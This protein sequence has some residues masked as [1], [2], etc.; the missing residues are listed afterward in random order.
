MAWTYSGDPSTSA[1]DMVRFLIADTDN[2][3]P[4]MTDAELDTLLTL[5]G[6]AEDTAYVCVKYLM[7][8][9][10]RECDYTIG[11]ESVKASQRYK[12]YK[13]LYAE[14]KFDRSI[15]HTTPQTA[16]STPIFTIG[17]MDDVGGL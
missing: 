14:L 11:P 3:D 10:A 1:R 12:Q 7:T 4:Q 15:K 17:M 6:A 16:N 13:Q 8:K 9:Y 2:T 5:H